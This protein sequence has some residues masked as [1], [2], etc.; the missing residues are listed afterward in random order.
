M[1]KK[2]YNKFSL[3]VLLAG[4]LGVAGVTGL[5]YFIITQV[6]GSTDGGGV[7]DKRIN[8]E[9]ENISYLAQVKH[10]D[11]ITDVEANEI[12]SGLKETINTKMNSLNLEENIDYTIDNLNEIKQG[13]RLDSI[14]IIVKAI[15]SSTKARGSLV[16]NLDGQE[17]INDRSIE[18]I[19]IPTSQENGLSVIRARNIRNEIQFSV[20]ELLSQ[21]QVNEEGVD[22]EIVNLDLIAAGA[23][24]TDYSNK[25]SVRALSNQLKGSF[26]INFEL[27]SNAN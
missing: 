17:N 23:K 5:I 14:N 11:S 25:I 20:Y 16:V 19:K 24:F 18:T 13:V 21:G 2:N 22:Y 9:L 10:M 8:L 3:S 7:D 27:D 4:I 12:I 26:T 1:K 6:N 15:E